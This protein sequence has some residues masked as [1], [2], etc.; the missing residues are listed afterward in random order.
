MSDK[1]A[2][3]RRG[4][5]LPDKYLSP[6]QIERLLRYLKRRAASGSRRAAVNQL[7]VWVLLYSGVRAEELLAIRIRNLPSHHGKD[8]IEIEH[9]KGNVSRSV[10]VPAWLSEVIRQF[11]KIYRKHAK[12]GSALIPSERGRRRIVHRRRSTREGR[13][14]TRRISERSA[15]L[16]YNSLWSKLS[17]IGRAA[18][19]GRLH[20]H[21][22]RHTYLCQLYAVKQD[23]LL[24]QRQA[25]HRDTK[26]TS[27]Y[28]QTTAEASVQQINALP[29]PQTISS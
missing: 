28:A 29:L 14:I 20:A 3:K 24:C 6:A 16:S 11:V 4:G 17:R 21:Q 25:G 10:I 19:V 1:A 8:V 12:P 15:R 18:G 22:F 27:I 23:V 9:G 26:T 2:T 5:L 7:I 13:C